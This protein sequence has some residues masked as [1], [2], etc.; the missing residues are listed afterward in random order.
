MQEDCILTSLGLPTKENKQ[1]NLPLS[2]HAQSASFFPGVPAT[3]N[4]KLGGMQVVWGGGWGNVDN[5]PLGN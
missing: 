1:P 3:V 4:G 2:L 5:W